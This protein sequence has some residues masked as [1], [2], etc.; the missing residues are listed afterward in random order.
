MIHPPG[1]AGGSTHT[2]LSSYA[3]SR[4]AAV[5]RSIARINSLSVAVVQL[6]RRIINKLCTSVSDSDTLYILV[7][8]ASPLRARLRGTCNAAIKSVHFISKHRVYYTLKIMQNTHDNI[9]HLYYSHIVIQIDII[10]VTLPEV[11][12]PAAGLYNNIYHI[13]YASVM[14]AKTTKTIVATQ[15]NAESRGS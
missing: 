15:L 6:P 8:S 4:S 10:S 2:V 3:P 11:Y 5:A 13:I 9:Y 1:R 7:N 14:T 12:A